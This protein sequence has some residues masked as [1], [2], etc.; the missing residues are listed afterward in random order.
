MD[1]IETLQLHHTRKSWITIGAF[2]GVHTGHQALFER[3]SQ[4]AKEAGSKSLVLTFD[5]LPAAFFNRI[6]TG[7]VLTTLEERIALIKSLGVDEVIVLRFDQQLADVN[8]ADFMQQVKNATGLERL[9]AGF[10]FSV[11]KDRLGTVT[12]L[13]EIGNQLD[14]QVEV[15]Q[16]VRHEREVVSSSAI[17]NLLKAGEIEKANL[18][19]GRAYT[20]TGLVIHGEHRGGKLGIPTANLAIPEER[21]LPVNGVYASTA[22]INGKT[23]TAVTNIGVRPTFENPL[24]APRVEPHLLD[25]NEEF[26]GETIDL[27]LVRYLRPE[28]KFLNAQALVDQIQKDIKLTREIINNET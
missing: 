24:P 13:K 25:T 3:L 22:L 8:A 2:D 11:G 5:P 1:Y 18:Y 21:L 4:G 20:L 23:Y 28:I 10:N 7:Q 15:V 12:A 9:L 17:R 6:Q 14:F 27:S 16:P 26:Y 19:L